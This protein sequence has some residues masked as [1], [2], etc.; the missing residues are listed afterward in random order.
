MDEFTSVLYDV[1][2]RSDVGCG[3]AKLLPGCQAPG[4]LLAL[5]ELTH[6]DAYLEPES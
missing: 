1:W 2:I 3:L 6:A 4:Q 5:H